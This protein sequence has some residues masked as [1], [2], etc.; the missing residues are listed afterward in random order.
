MKIQ[1]QDAKELALELG[2]LS[3]NLKTM[4]KAKTNF[5]L[6]NYYDKKDAFHFLISLGASTEQA[7]QA[8]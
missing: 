2:R 4:R 8:L 7:K 5:K 1:L 6:L 3:Q